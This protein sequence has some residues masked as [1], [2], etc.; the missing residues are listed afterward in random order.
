MDLIDFASKALSVP[1]TLLVMWL[2][3][4]QIREIYRK[5]SRRSPVTMRAGIIVKHPFSLSQNVGIWLIAAALFVGMCFIN[6]GLWQ[7]ERFLAY[8]GGNFIMIAILLTFHIHWKRRTTEEQH[9]LKYKR[10][11]TAR[12]KGKALKRPRP[13]V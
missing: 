2:T 12:E 4:L 13:S 7:A 10:E 8:V 11:R 9:I 1:S 6:K 3:W 5:G